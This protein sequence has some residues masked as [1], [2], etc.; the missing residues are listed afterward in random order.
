M[1]SKRIGP[2]TVIAKLGSGGM[3]DVY[4]AAK[5]GPGGFSRPVVIKQVRKEL[6]SQPELRAMFADE[7]R[8][9]ARIQHTNVVVVEDFGEADG[10][11]YLVMEY[12]HGVP[13]IALLRRLSELSRRLAPVAAVAIAAPIADGL[14]AAHEAS[15]AD[16]QPLNLVHRDV[17][18]Q[19]ILLSVG[20]TPKLIDFGIAKADARLHRTEGQVIKGKLRYMAPEQMVGTVDRRADL[21][22]LG[23]VLWEMLTGRRLVTDE[24][25]EDV[26]RRVRAGHFDPPSRHAQIPAALD[27]LVMRTLATDPAERPATGRQLRRALLDALPDA[28]QLEP[29]RLAALLM[30]TMGPELEDRARRL[31]VP[32]GAP[33]DTAEMSREPIRALEELT[34]PVVVPGPPS[35]IAPPPALSEPPALSPPHAPDALSPPHAPDAPTPAETAAAHP[36]PPPRRVALLAAALGAAALAALFGAR[37]FLSAVPPERPTVG[38]P[39]VGAPP[40]AGAPETR[41]APASHGEPPNEQPGALADETPTRGSPTSQPALGTSFGERAPGLGSNS[42]GGTER[43]EPAEAFEEHSAHGRM[44]MGS[45]ASQRPRARPRAARAKPRRRSAADEFPLAEVDDPFAD[46]F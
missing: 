21:Y 10:R 17:S 43:A 11:L 27:A 46:D 25:P 34:V 30:A 3:A 22:A 5:E 9:S 15:D 42:G 29:S 12:V 44:A 36:E 6:A 31:M 14:H 38:A 18:P 40:P 39:L 16:G 26:I 8:L 4:L 41:T 24:A 1:R 32:L 28:A 45:E 23:V 20:G 7:A 13:L 33:L 19:N 2:F 37:L 35:R